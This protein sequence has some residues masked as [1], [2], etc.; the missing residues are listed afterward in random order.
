MLSSYINSYILVLDSSLNNLSFET[1]RRQKRKTLPHDQICPSKSKYK[2]LKGDESLEEIE[3]D[4]L[5]NFFM[6]KGRWQ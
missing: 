5:G 6:I 3:E 1:F 4:Y 2:K